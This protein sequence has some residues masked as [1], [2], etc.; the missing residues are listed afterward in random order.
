MS[1][2]A[3]DGSQP[4]LVPWPFGL[5]KET[6]R[7]AD[8]SRSAWEAFTLA[9]RLKVRCSDGPVS[10][11]FAQPFI[12]APTQV[13]QCIAWRTLGAVRTYT[14]ASTPLGPW[15]RLRVRPPLLPHSRW[16]A[17][18]ITRRPRMTDATSD[19][20]RF[21]YSGHSIGDDHCIPRREQ[22]T[23]ASEVLHPYVNSQAPKLFGAPLTARSGR[24][25]HCQSGPI[26]PNSDPTARQVIL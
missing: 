14:R 13:P 24:V 16:R 5:L 21:R 3:P 7:P 12:V 19:Q 6:V 23:V 22:A 17:L 4:S 25:V 10:Q 26:D 1:L 2:R 9:R 18:S 8:A 15:I 20:S 11:P